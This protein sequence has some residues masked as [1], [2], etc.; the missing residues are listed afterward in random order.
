MGDGKKYPEVPV[1]KLRWRCPPD[2]LPFETTDEIKP[3]LDI[4]GQERALRAIR[5]G[6]EVDSLGYN[7]FVVGLVGTG[8]NTTI[9]CLLEE[10]DK[11]GKIPD[12]ICYVNNFKDPDQ[13][14]CVYL[15]AG[16]GKVFKKG[17]DDLIESLKKQ[18]PLVFESE[19]YQRRKRELVEKHREREK[20]LVKEFENR[21]KKE[22]FT[23][24]QVQMGPLPVPMWSPWWPAMPCL[25]ISWKTWSIRGSF[26]RKPS[27]S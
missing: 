14:K 19:E 11:T 18:I 9:K 24:V 2:S 12:D 27:S 20:G 13:P 10:I 5:L 15:P 4:I 22:G 3:C 25:S 26:R 1:E 23:V 7:I 17:M 6:L 16:Q 21:A 8:R